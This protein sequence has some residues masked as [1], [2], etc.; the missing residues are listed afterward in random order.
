MQGSP[1]GGLYYLWHPGTR[2]RF[3]GYGLVIAPWRLVGI[4]MVDRPTVADPAWLADIERT[5]GSNQL[6]A[7]T[8]TGER[9]IVCQ[10]EVAENSRQE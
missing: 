2:D 8:H 10:M 9:G 1:G 4:I 6:T 3:S 5:F 7:M